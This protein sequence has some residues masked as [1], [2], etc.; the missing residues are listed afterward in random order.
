MYMDTEWGHGL[1]HISF[2]LFDKVK[3]FSSFF[4]HITFFHL[5]KH[6][7]NKI[8]AYFRYFFLSAIGSSPFASCSHEKNKNN[9][10]LHVTQVFGVLCLLNLFSLY[11]DT[12]T[13]T[14][15]QSVTIA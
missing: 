6:G 7:K 10:L 4:P 14:H 13:Y 5:L 9:F 1:P 2:H 12:H 3:W 8:N 15:T 11:T